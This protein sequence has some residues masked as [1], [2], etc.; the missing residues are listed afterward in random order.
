MLV[1]DAYRVKGNPGSRFDHFDVHVVYTKENETGD[2]YI[3]KLANSIGRNYRV[4]VV[5]SDALI[6]LSALRSGVLR[7][8]APEFEREVNDILARIDRFIQGTMEK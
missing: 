7:M 5:T 6:Q 4:R 8:S 1:F 3:E 2:L